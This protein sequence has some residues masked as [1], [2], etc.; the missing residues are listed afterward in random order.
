MVDEEVFHAMIGFLS[1]SFPRVWGKMEVEMMGEA[2]LTMLLRW[3]GS[4]PTLLP[5]LFISHYDVVPITKGTEEDWTHPPF[6]GA[7][8]DG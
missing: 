4:D 7:V 1:S 5:I 6:S 3:P 8:Q 2:N